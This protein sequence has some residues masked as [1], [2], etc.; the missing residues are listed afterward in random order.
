MNRIAVKMLIGDRMKYLSLVAGLVFAALLITQQTS[1]YNGFGELTEG[2]LRDTAVADLWVMDDQVEHAD[3]MKPMLENEL[4]RVRGVEGVAWAVPMFKSYVNAILPDGTRQNLRLIGLDDATLMG[5]PPEM[6]QGAIEDLRRDKAVLLN[7]R[8]PLVMKKQGGDVKVGEHFSLNDHEVVA[9]GSY[10]G[11]KEFFWEPVLYTTYSKAKFITRD[12]RRFMQYVL[13]KVRPGADIAEVAR[14]IETIPG[15]LAL[16]GP[17]FRQTTRQWILNKT[18]IN[19]NFG[20]MIVLGYVIGVLVAGQTLYAFVLDNLK[21]FAALKAMGAGDWVLVRMVLV[22]VLVA[23][24]VAFGVGAGCAAA[25][26]RIL[27]GAGLSFVMNWSIL[28]TGFCGLLACT[29]LAASLSLVRVL[30]LEPAVVF[31]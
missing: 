11:S 30:R 19:I 29:A 18:G 25:T 28:G 23:T 10:R 21:Y 6:V 3:D 13:V 26:G 20:I 27:A 1:I 22:Q 17:T 9:V 14:R 2:W 15:L 4:L 8:L 12:H 7:A 5:G 24:T 16:D 31:K